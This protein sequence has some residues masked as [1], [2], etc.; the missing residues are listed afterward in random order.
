MDQ[1]DVGWWVVVGV[2]ECVVSVVHQGHVRGGS[3]LLV[4]GGPDVARDMVP[5]VAQGGH[6]VDPSPPFPRHGVRVG[7]AGLGMRH[8]GL[9]VA[10]AALGVHPPR[11]EVYDKV[12]PP[13]PGSV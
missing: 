2:V 11:L 1:P 13:V 7:G 10:G 6:T 12:S 9:V 3:W 8:V 5:E 4:V